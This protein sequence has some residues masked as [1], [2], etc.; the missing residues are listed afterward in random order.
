MAINWIKSNWTILAMLGGIGVY[1]IQTDRD[2]KNNFENIDK[3]ISSIKDTATERANIADDRYAEQDKLNLPIRVANL[4]SQVRD[5]L[6]LIQRGQDRQEQT[7]AQIAE[8]LQN[9][10]IQVSVVASKVDDLKGGSPRK[11]NLLFSPRPMK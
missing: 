7:T 11:T 4:E 6:V 8:K 10:S 3:A 5:I 9:I 1:M 2:T